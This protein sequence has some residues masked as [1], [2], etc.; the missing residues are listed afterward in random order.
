MAPNQL[1]CWLNVHFAPSTG[2]FASGELDKAAC[3]VCVGFLA[4]LPILGAGSP[5]DRIVP[6]SACRTIDHDH[7]IRIRLG[8]QAGAGG[9]APGGGGARG[10]AAG[11][12]AGPRAGRRGAAPGA[13]AVRGGGST[14]HTGEEGGEPASPR[15]SGIPT[16]NHE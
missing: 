4:F 5:S 6:L 3:W 16:Q 14:Q 15:T 1:D 9:R 8:I 7:R 2:T 12:A 10:G 13:G 11:G